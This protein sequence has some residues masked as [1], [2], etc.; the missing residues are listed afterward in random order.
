ML[1]FNYIDDEL[2]NVII[3]LLTKTDGVAPTIAD[4]QKI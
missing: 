2:K 1:N 3:T 4:L